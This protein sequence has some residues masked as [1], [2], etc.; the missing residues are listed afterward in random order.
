MKY[1]VY[2]Q[3]DAGLSL[4]VDAEN[5]EDA[6]AQAWQE[7]AYGHSDVEVGEAIEILEL[8]E[9]AEKQVDR[10]VVPKGTQVE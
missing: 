7:A 8:E 4:V 10:A 6:R 1:R 5:D 2:I 9:V 3:Y